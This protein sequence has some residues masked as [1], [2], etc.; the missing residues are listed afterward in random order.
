MSLL[1]VN[2]FLYVVFL[3]SL[4]YSGYLEKGKYFVFQELEELIHILELYQRRL[5]SLLLI[6]NRAKQGRDILSKI[7]SGSFPKRH[8]GKFSCPVSTGFARADVQFCS[9]IV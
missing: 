2:L 4:S 9:A 7:F 6:L 8:L 5:S 1:I 3:G